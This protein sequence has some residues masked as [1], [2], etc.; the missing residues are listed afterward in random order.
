MK[1]KI[2]VDSSCDVN[3]DYL[4][5]TGVDLAVIPF[6]V[7]VGEKAFVDDDGLDTQEL[8][9]ALENFSDKPISACPSPQAFLDELTG[10]DKYFIITI[11][12]KLS[13]SYNSG[14]VAKNL[15][16]TPNDVFVIDS[17][18]TSGGEIF[19]IDKIVELINAN[20]DFSEICDSVIEY[21]YQ[22]TELLFT[23][24]DYSNLVK[25]GRMTPLQAV[26]ATTLRIKPV[27]A[28]QNGEIKIIKKLLGAKRLLRELVLTM[29]EKKQTFGC[30]K[31]IITHADNLEDANELKDAL[32]EKNI[33]SQVEVLPM[34]GLC[35]FYAMRKGLIICFEK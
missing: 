15:C 22:K 30:G 34:K 3:K 8:L 12:S 27:C 18:Q 28:A 7:N 5:G 33:F 11:S 10:A 13:G 2:I 31:C 32:I 19:I 4:S 16:A 23:L 29:Q 14:I 35:S 24:K 21:S 26:I 25:N 20:K 1:Y 6:T 9:T 17:K